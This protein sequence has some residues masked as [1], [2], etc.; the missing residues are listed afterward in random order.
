[1]FVTF[2]M[3][4]TEFKNT[5]GSNYSIA[6]PFQPGITIAVLLVVVFPG[7]VVLVVIVLTVVVGKPTFTMFVIA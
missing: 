1:M 5:S 6:V 3:P 7:I 4:R 2:V